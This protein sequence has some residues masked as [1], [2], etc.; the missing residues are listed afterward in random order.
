MSSKVVNVSSTNGENYLF[1]GGGSEFAHWHLL[2]FIL[3][4][5][6]TEVA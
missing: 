6:L 5:K 3:R 4:R 2:A 1:Q